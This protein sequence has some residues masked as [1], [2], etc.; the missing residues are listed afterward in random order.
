[1][2][3]ADIY[4]KTCKTIQVCMLSSAARAVRR[5]HLTYLSL[6]K[7]RRLET[8]L[9]ELDTH[10]I[11]GDY[12]EFGVALGGSAI[13]I[14]KAAQKSRRAFTGFDVFGTIPAPTSLK[15]DAKS[16]ERY[17]AIAEGHSDGIG[18][19]RYYGYRDD[20]YGDVVGAFAR[21]GLTVGIGGLA[22]ER[23]LFQNTCPK[24][25]TE[26]IA[27]AHI[28]CDWYEPVH[29]CLNAL[30]HAMVPGGVILLDD[31]HDYGGARIATQEFLVE[32]GDFAF[33]D[34]ENVILR[35]RRAQ[36]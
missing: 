6:P 30:C 1:M 28:D 15:D 26:M 27:F 16:K 19:E 36:V 35:L 32:R 34:G 14:A 5:E 29:Y 20:L 23:G 8:V 33:E 25:T 12:V 24:W 21:F 31:Y 4:D 13:L 17:R 3:V 2:R 9:S 10:H 11:A 18:G 7:L 22:L